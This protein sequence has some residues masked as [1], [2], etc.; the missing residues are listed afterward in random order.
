MGTA[1][2]LRKQK[3]KVTPIATWRRARVVEWAALEMRYARKGI[4][5]SNPLASARKDF[6]NA[7][8]SPRFARRLICMGFLAKK[9]RIYQTKYG[10][11]RF[12]LEMLSFRTYPHSV[13]ILTRD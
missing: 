12:V 6:A 1:A 8:C 13:T 4:R 9:K 2:L 11:S 7:N 10:S 3:A 5:G